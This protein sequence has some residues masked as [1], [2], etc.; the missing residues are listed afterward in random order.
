[1]RASLAHEARPLDRQGASGERYAL[2]PSLDR[3]ILPISSRFGFVGEWANFQEAFKWV[4]P[5]RLGNACFVLRVAVCEN[6]Q[7]EGC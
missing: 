2:G 7:W 5:L 1:M 6:R 3:L 4:G